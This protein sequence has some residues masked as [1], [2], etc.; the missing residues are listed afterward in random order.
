MKNINFLKHLAIA[1]LICYG[2]SLT[3][4][5]NYNPYAS[6]YHHQVNEPSFMQ[7]VASVG[8]S[9]MAT[10]SVLYMGA[11][12]WSLLPDSKALAAPTNSGD[13][14]I[15]RTTFNDV[16]GAQEAK[17]A[18]S[19]IV[20][21]LR[22]PE[23][24]ENIGAR[25][26]KGILLE[27]NPGN[28]KTLLAK[29][30]AG[31]V[32]VNFIAVNGASFTDKYAGVGVSRVKN[33]FEK[34]AAHAPCIIFIDEIDGLGSRARPGEE[35]QVVMD[36]NRTI[37]EFLTQMDGFATD[38]K[39]SIIV[40]G[41]TNHRNLIDPALLRSGRFDTI[42]RVE[43]PTTADRK[44]IMQLYAKKI[45]T[46][47]QIDFDTLAQ[48]AVHFS[49]ADLEN[50][51]NQAALIAVRRKS[52]VVEQADF[53]KALDQLTRTRIKNKPDQIINSIAI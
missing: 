49:G 23:K 9:I 52:A 2:S 12:I 48:N 3:A 28:G 43:N 18:L 17:E 53:D 16:I 1:G 32:K 27:G 24:Y 29:A 21:M 33:L 10:V 42:V 39:K 5:Q 51:V 13:V 40:I 31:E 37:T 20:E 35:S 14:T 8:Q 7:G 6:Q 34:A 25:L 22:N 15:P 26:P 38:P 41:A 44:A 47:T 36:W 30:F 45:K 19:D 4:N 50:L 11:L 46:N